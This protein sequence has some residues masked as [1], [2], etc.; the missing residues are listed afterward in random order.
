MS[1]LIRWQSNTNL[2]KSYTHVSDS[3]RNSNKIIP[4]QILSSNDIPGLS[5][6]LMSNR[7][8]RLLE[9]GSV[10]GR[11]VPGNLSTRTSEQ[12]ILA[13]LY[14]R[15]HRKS[16]QQNSY[17]ITKVNDWSGTSRDKNIFM[18]SNNF[19]SR[20][21]CSCSFLRLAIL[22]V[23]NVLNKYRKIRAIIAG[24]FFVGSPLQEIRL[25]RIRPLVLIRWFSPTLATEHTRAKRKITCGT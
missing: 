10:A 19:N 18:P 11:L 24:V 4:W 9:C 21:S 5:N 14:N 7:L 23:V 16:K 6:D 20:C 8:V 25:E 13:I 3:S 15:K 12:K 22:L 1:N 2:P 17:L